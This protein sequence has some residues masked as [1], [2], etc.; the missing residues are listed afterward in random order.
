[1]VCGVSSGFFLFF[2]FLCYHR[3][4]CFKKGLFFVEN[5]DLPV[6]V[7]VTGRCK[8]SDCSHDII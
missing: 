6:L 4:C 3:L 2:N 8:Q 1:M 5:I 7:D